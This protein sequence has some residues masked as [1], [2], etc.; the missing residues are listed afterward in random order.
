MI[1][2][3]KFTNQESFESKVRAEEVMKYVHLLDNCR[4]N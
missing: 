3:I 1:E 4:G 2:H